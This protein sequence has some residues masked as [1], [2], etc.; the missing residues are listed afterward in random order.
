MYRD[1]GV[2]TRKC[3]GY[4]KK[5][6]YAQTYRKNGMYTNK[7]STGKVASEPAICVVFSK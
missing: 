7:E 2:S 3:G 4:Y 1:G 5:K 6:H